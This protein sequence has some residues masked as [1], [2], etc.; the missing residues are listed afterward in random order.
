[1]FFKLAFEKAEIANLSSE[2]RSEYEHNLK[3]YRDYKNTIDTAF[4]EGKLECKLERNFEMAKTL[5]ENGVAIEI[6]IK[7]TGLSKE[8]FDK[9]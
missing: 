6:I 7:T 3:V 8:E 4:D 2:E 5:K 9:L 1:M